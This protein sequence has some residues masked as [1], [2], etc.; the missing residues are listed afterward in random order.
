MMTWS[1]PFSVGTAPLAGF[2]VIAATIAPIGIANLPVRRP[3]K[4][5]PPRIRNLSRL[6]TLPRRQ[7]SVDSP[8]ELRHGSTRRPVERGLNWK[9][10]RSGHGCKFGV[11]AVECSAHSS[12]DRSRLLAGSKVGSRC[13]DDLAHAFDSPHSRKLN[14]GGM[15][16]PSEQLRPGEAEGL[17]LD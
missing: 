3:T 9:P 13:L 12:H 8:N 2:R 4:E 5:V 10:R 1:A 6:E 16:L 7:R 17:D 11:T 14:A 15:P